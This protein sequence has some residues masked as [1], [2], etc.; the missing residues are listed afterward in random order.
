ML[1]RVYPIFLILLFAG[2][3]LIPAFI[4]GYP[5]VYS[6]TGTYISSGFLGEVPTDR[7]IS[8]GLFLRHSSLS[9]SLWFTVL[10][11]ALL[12]S[13][14]IYFFVSFFWKK[15]ENR[16]LVYGIAMLFLTFF[17]SLPWFTDLLMADFFTGLSFILLMILLLFPPKKIWIFVLLIWVYWFFTSTHLTHAPAHLF[18]LFGLVLLKWLLPK[19]LAILTWKSIKL[20]FVLV[21]LNFLFLPSLHYLFNGGFVSSKAGALFMLAKNIENGSVQTYLND[22]CK[23]ENYKLCLYKDSLPKSGPEFLWDPQSALVKIGGWEKN[24]EEIE[25]INHHIF[26]EP[27]YLKIYLKHYSASLYQNIKYHR[28]GEEFISFNENTP[29][30]WEID[31]HFK[32]EKE[33]FLNAMQAKDKWTDC[34]SLLNTLLL[35]VLIVSVLIVFLLL[36]FADPNPPL[37]TFALAVLIFSLGNVLVVNIASGGSRYLARVDWLIVLAALLL[38]LDLKPIRNWFKKTI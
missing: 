25:A 12:V 9:Y 3:L 13:T 8:Y 16:N 18:L 29:P 22:A 32:R 10:T 5:F 7:P 37:A 27:K 2:I 19:R 6:D 21:L 17:S 35:P 14:A 28:V 15:D 34:L 31:A 33:Q 23:G 36:V 24:K 38:M 20:T 11:Q 30:G 26:F 1:Q 4:N